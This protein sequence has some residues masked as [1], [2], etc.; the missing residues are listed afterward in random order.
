MKSIAVGVDAGR[1]DHIGFNI[2][3][4]TKKV[5]RTAPLGTGATMQ[6]MTKMEQELLREIADIDNILQGHGN[7]NYVNGFLVGLGST[8]Q[9]LR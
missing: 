7:L 6:A 5:M 9:L 8:K 4:R 3:R 1:Y 2:K